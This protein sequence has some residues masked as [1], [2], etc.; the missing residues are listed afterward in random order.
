MAPAPKLTIHKWDLLKP[1]SLSKAFYIADRTKWKEKIS[2]RKL[3]CK[4]LTEIEKSDTILYRIINRRVS[5]GQE[6]LKEMV[7]FLMLQENGIQSNQI[8]NLKIVCMA[9]VKT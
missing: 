1:K 8:F 9:K 7:K 4:I 6:A 3:L 2:D 5:N